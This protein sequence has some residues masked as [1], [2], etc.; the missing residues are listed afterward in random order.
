[1]PPTK[2]TFDTELDRIFHE[3]AELGF[4][5]VGLTAGKLHRMVGDYPSR[6]NNRMP[7]CCKCMRD[8]MRPDAG[9]RTIEAPPK[10]DGANLLIHYVIPRPQQ[11]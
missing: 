10:G 8:K 1:M 4:S 2:L 9:D 11:T 5:Y 6:T 3:V 7:L